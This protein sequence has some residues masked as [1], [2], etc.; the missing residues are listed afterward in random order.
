MVPNWPLGR[1]MS[2]HK[3]A[4]RRS[5]AGKAAHS[6]G[7]AFALRPLAP[8][9]TPPMFLQGTGKTATEYVSD[10]LLRQPPL[11]EQMRVRAYRSKRGAAPNPDD[12]ASHYGVEPPRVLVVVPKSAG[13]TTACKILTNY[14]VRGPTPAFP[15]IANLDLGDVCPLV[16]RF[17]STHAQCAGGWTLHVQLTRLFRPPHQLIHWES[18]QP[19]RHQSCRLSSIGLVTQTCG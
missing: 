4:K 3:N 2:S 17:P 16:T 8:G 12:E 1:L 15:P 11:L 14:A 5:T 7:V 6:R 9:L 19:L 18:P 10:D 13:N